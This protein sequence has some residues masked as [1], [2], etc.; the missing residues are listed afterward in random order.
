MQLLNRMGEQWG[1][2]DLAESA[3]CIIAI[4]GMAVSLGRI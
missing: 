4:A 1:F 2:R 3:T